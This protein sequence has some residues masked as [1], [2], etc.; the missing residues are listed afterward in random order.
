VEPNINSTTKIFNALANIKPITAAKLYKNYTL[1]VSDSYGI[2]ISSV[3]FEVNDKKI[4]ST[5]VDYV[6]MQ[7]LRDR[8]FAETEHLRT[9]NS[10]YYESMLKMVLHVQESNN[11]KIW[12]PT[13]N[14][15][16]K[17]NLPEYKA[18]ALEKIID[19]EKTK[20]YK[21]KSSYLRIPK[22]MTKSEFDPSLSHYFNIDGREN[23]NSTHTNL[24]WIS[25]KIIAKT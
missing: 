18:F 10:L 19:P 16:G 5:T 6:L 15:Y 21:P 11:D 2:R 12:F 4:I 23:T 25:D 14:C 13:I 22:C 24:K 20:L 3:Q 8:V 9:I 1:E 7:F 17:T